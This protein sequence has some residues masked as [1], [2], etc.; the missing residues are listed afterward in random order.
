MSSL[1]ERSPTSL[2]ASESRRQPVDAG[3]AN[4]SPA[5]PTKAPSSPLRSWLLVLAAGLF[6]G[7]AG[8]GIGEVAPRFYPVSYEFSPEIRRNTARVPI[9]LERRMRVSRDQSA[10]LAYGGLGMVLGLALGVAGGLARRSLGPAIAAG[11]VGLVLGGAAGAGMTRVLLPFYHATR[12]AASEADQNN[13]LALALRTHGGI[14]LAIGAAAG[15]ALGIGLGGGARMARALIGG[16]LGAGVAAVI[17]EFGGAVVFPVAETFRPMAYQMIPRLLAHLA[18]AL[19]VAAGA[20][21]VADHL[22]LRRSTPR[23]DR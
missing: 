6:A 4:E 5:G 15:L 16:I 11:V 23:P 18:V 7:L 20:L 22:A 3:L 13:D 10:T 19:C 2:G 9:E 17:Y 14:W 21:L 12:A 1:D 8:F